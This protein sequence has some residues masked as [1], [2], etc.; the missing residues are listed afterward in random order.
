MDSQVSHGAKN[1]GTVSIF[2][3]GVFDRKIIKR[4]TLCKIDRFFFLVCGSGR[5]AVSTSY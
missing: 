4:A 3:A 5:A 1:E 2:A